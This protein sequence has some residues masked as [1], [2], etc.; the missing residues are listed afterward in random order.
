M[1]EIKL[2]FGKCSNIDEDYCEDCKRYNT[3]ECD[4]EKVDQNEYDFRTD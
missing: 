2:L 4:F 3:H 1:S